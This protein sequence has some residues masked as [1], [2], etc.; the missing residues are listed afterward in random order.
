V[1]RRP[2]YPEDLIQK[3][4]GFVVTLAKKF[5]NMP[6]AELDD[7]VQEGCCGVL[8]AWVTFD[9]SKGAKFITH[10]YWWIR[11][12]I[13]YYLVHKTQLI[14]VP[15]YKRSGIL[16][17]HQSTDNPYSLSTPISHN[18]ETLTLGD[19]IAIKGN[20]MDNIEEQ[21]MMNTL[22]ARLETRHRKLIME[23][24]GL[25]GKGPKTLREVGS[26]HKISRERVRQLNERSIKSIK[27]WIK[28]QEVI[29]G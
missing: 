19:C 15:S 28:Q 12:Y 21:D 27:A 5:V 26:K 14:Y 9:E 29:Y 25:D 17:E 6:G 10:A 13:G 4:F 23:Y 16:K 18:D 7:M 11:A 3:Y 22:L 8:K 2:S 24:Y 20:F 1:P